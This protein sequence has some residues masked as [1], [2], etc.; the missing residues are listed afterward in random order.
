M[1][2]KNTICNFLR[3]MDTFKRFTTKTLLEIS[4]IMEYHRML[5]EQTRERLK[6]QYYIVISGLFYFLTHELSDEKD[7]V[8]NSVMTISTAPWNVQSTS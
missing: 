6:G 1:A 7:F 8:G 2:H 3:T 5:A 4:S